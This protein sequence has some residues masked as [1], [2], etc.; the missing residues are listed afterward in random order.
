MKKDSKEDYSK[1][2][3][4]LKKIG[5]ATLI[6][7][8]TPV[9]LDASRTVINKLGLKKRVLPVPG[10]VVYRD[11][12]V[13]YAEHSGI[14]VGGSD[15]CIVELQR[16]NG[17]CKITRVSIDEFMENGLGHDYIYVSSKDGESVGSQMLA[18]CALRMVGQDLGDYE[19]LGNNCHMFVCDCLRLLLNSGD[20]ICEAGRECDSNISYPKFTLS[21][22]K[23]ESKKMLGADSWLIWDRAKQL[24]TEM[25]ATSDDS[26]LDQ[27]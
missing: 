18:D 15:K 1:K 16:R 4:T 25:I 22:L 23:H 7:M 20:C 26:Y 21:N 6:A 27:Q 8:A 17:R 12:F 9:A 11:L 10:S 3:N 19:L 2:L 5:L 13:G 24:Q 14:Y